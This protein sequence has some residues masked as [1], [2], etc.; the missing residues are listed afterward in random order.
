MMEILRR[1][2]ILKGRSRSFLSTLSE[3]KAFFQLK[4]VIVSINRIFLLQASLGFRSV[5]E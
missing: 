4:G 5:E 3:E 2:K 1:L